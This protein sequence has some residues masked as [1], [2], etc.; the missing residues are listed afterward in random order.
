V[1]E[2]TP[3]DLR[4]RH[5]ALLFRQDRDDLFFAEFALPHCLSPCDR[6]SIQMRDQTGL[7][8]AATKDSKYN[9]QYEARRGG[10][11]RCAIL[12]CNSFETVAQDIWEATYTDEVTG[13]VSLAAADVED[14]VG[15]KT[16]V[17]FPDNIVSR[18]QVGASDVNEIA[19]QIISTHEGPGHGMG[20]GHV[21][22][23]GNI[24]NP[25]VDQIG[26][27]SVPQFSDEQIEKILSHQAS[28]VREN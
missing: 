4:G 19:L 6:L 10:L 5:P 9:V 15:G 22:D 27:T 18:T 7:R 8:S 11:L 23:E 13:T 28:R 16:Q 1:A 14:M 12:G 20:L 2:L 17:L 25:T 26:A 21:S 3:A 24:M